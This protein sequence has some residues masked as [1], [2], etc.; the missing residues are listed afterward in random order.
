[1]DADSSTSSHTAE[2]G[3]IK[4]DL[5]HVRE[6]Y[7]VNDFHNLENH[8][9]SFFEQKEYVVLDRLKTQTFKK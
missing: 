4:K 9:E 6:K 2:A 3:Y 7:I 5:Q 8:A 1:M